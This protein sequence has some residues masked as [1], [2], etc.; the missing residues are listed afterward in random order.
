MLFHTSDITTHWFTN[1]SCKS[2]YER[3]NVTR[4]RMIQKGNKRLA[5]NDNDDGKEQKEIL[6][7]KTFQAML[8]LFFLNNRLTMNKFMN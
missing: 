2:Y 1:I 4:S 6:S 3:Y 7:A 8:F 5:T